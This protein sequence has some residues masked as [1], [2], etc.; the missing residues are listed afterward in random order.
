VVPVAGLLAE[1]A[2]TGQLTESDAR[3][4]HTLARYDP[5]DLFDLLESDNPGPV[6]PQMRDRLLD[7]VGEYGLVLGREVAARGAY[8]LNSWLS[9]SSGIQA[10]QHVLYTVLH[11]FA[12]M[13]RCDRIMIE[14]D[15]LVYTHPARDP[16]RAIVQSIRADPA[17]QPVL[18]YRN[19]RSLLQAD[20]QSPLVGDLRRLLSGATDAERMGLP[21]NVHPQEVLNAIASRLAWVQQRAIATSSAAEDAAVAQLIGVYGRMRRG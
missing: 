16:I 18:M 13:H 11:R 2:H 19:L 17:M 14:L 7:L 10:L 6:T 1:T 15:N 21:P 8:A 5:L 3:S 20:P 4:L 12:A 9:Q